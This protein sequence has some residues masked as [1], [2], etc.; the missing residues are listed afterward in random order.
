MSGPD[1]PKPR[2]VTALLRDWRAGDPGAID[3]LLALV[4]RQLH[5]TAAAYLAREGRGH[6]LQATA[7]VNEAFIKLVAQNRIEWENRSH[8]FGIAATLMRRILVDHARRQHRTKRGGFA[9]KVS[10]DELAVEPAAATPAGDVIDVFARDRALQKL[11][12]L[13]PRVGRV[14]ELRFFGGLGV[15]ETAEIM[16]ISPGTVKRDWAMAKAFLFRELSGSDGGPGR[17]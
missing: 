3:E 17:G 1:G 14:V 11:E 10:L 7:L 12:H 5:A 13:D 15:E 4:Y 8:F 16:E 9:A 6:T 2:E